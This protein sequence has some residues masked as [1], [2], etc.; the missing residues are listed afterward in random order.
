M[1]QHIPIESFTQQRFEE[2][3]K[4]IENA[5]T[6]SRGMMKTSNKYIFNENLTAIYKNGCD[7]Y[8]TNYH[9][10]KGFVWGTETG[11]FEIHFDREFKKIR[12]IF[13]VA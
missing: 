12:D 7:V 3:K 4:G 6:K 10:G 8:L 13:L 1:A 11:G 2:I 5:F 9:I